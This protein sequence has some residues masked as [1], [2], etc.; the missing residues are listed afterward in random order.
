MFSYVLV[1]IWIVSAV[2]GYELAKRRGV[3]L[4]FFCNMGFVFLGP[5]ALP[6][7]FLL[8][9]KKPQPSQ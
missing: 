4:G 2:I 9:A 7:V 1:F 8:K 6:F 3:K 5:L